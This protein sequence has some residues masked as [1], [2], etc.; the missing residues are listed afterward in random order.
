[1][2]ATG[3]SQVVA[4]DQSAQGVEVAFA[5]GHGVCGDVVVGADGVQSVCRTALTGQA[6]PATYAGYVAW[7]GLEDETSLP[8]DVVAQLAGRFTLLDVAERWLPRLLARLVARSVVFMQ[9]VQDLMPAQYT[10]SGTSKAFADA[11]TLASALDGWRADQPLP[12]RRLE[13][14]EQQRREELV[15]L[16]RAGLRLAAGSGLGVPGAAAPWI[17]G[18]A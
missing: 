11:T 5:D 8:E 2:P 6:D 7:R 12:Q 17:G 9:P 4:I 1:M 3:K 18:A 13:Q 16:V 10:A 14:W 15:R